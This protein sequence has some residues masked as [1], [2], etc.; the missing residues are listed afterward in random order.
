MNRMKNAIGFYMMPKPP[1]TVKYG[2]LYN[3]YVVEG[4]G[5]IIDWFLPSKDELNLMYTNLQLFGLGGFSNI[6]Y[7]SSSETGTSAWWQYFLNGTQGTSAKISGLNGVR[8]CRAFT[9]VSPSYS[10]GDVGPAGGR[11]FYK[12]GNDYLEAASTDLSAGCNWSNISTAIGTTDTAIGTGQA[13]TNAIIGQVGHTA[14]AAKLCGDLIINISSSIANTGWHVPTEAEFG[15]LITY[16]GGSS[17][18]GGHLKETGTSY[19]NS[20]N[21]GDNSSGFSFKGTGLKYTTY[22]PSF[23]LIKRTGYLWTYTPY[24]STKGKYLYINYNSSHTYIKEILFNHGLAVRLIKDFTTLSNGQT[25]T[26]T[27]NDGRIYPTICIGTQE[28]VADN[29][30]ET[31]YRNGNTIPEVTDATA[32]DALTTGALCAYNNEWSHVMN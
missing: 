6:G 9:S 19:W 27:G 2:L 10:L 26:Y 11:I 1:T 4:G 14:S 3:W 17:V 5:T 31:K 18:A 7:W 12:S 29:L 13:N 8:A 30:A 25:G 23:G 21:T 22:E 20:P 24:D 28:W 16:L 15:T 32:W